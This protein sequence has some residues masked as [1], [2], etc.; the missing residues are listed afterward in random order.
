MALFPLTNDET[1]AQRVTCP[2]HIVQKGEGSAWIPAG[3]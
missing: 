2:A 1:E 3:L